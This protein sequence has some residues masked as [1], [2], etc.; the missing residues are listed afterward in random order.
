MAAASEVKTL[1]QWVS[2]IGLGVA[3]KLPYF[4][5]RKLKTSD[6]RGLFILAINSNNQG[7]FVFD[8]KQM[9]P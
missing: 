7:R 6:S 1:R 8:I 3:Y 4:N 5:S 2:F 9:V